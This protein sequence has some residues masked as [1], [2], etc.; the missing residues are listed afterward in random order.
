[1]K[2]SRTPIPFLVHLSVILSSLLVFASCGGSGSGGGGG[3]EEQPGIVSVPS[4]Y[5]QGCGASAYGGRGGTVY[6]VTNLED[7]GASED[8]IIGSLRAA[9]MKRDSRTIVFR[10]SGTIHLKRVLKPSNG[11]FT[12]AG[13]TAPGD[14]ITLADYP[15]VLSGLQNVVVQFLRFRLGDGITSDAYDAFEGQNNNNVMIDHCSMSWS[16]D[17]CASFYG[18]T[19]FTMQW[20]VI[21]ES[22]KGSSHPKGNHGYGGIWGGTNATFHHNL[23]ADHDSR[24]PRFDHDYVNSSCRGPVDFVNNVVF[25]WGGNSSYGGESAGAYRTVNVE[26]NYYRPGPNTKSGRRSQILN[27]TCSCGYCAERGTV[28]PGKFYVNGNVMDGASDV[29]ADNSIGVKPD[30]DSKKASILQSAHFPM[31]VELYHRESA[32]DALSSVLAYAGASKARDAVDTRVINQVMGN[33]EGKIIDSQN[34]VGGWPELNTTTPPLDS[35]SDGIP[36]EWEDAYGLN[37]N[38][39]TDGA[40]RTLDVAHLRSNL[41]IYCYDIVKDLYR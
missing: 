13:Q 26:N 40:K 39:R 6:Y 1:M 12:I 3:E 11:N 10:V 28:F 2:H 34:D 20:C 16:V 33:E 21:A 14:G 19:N 31:A 32:A 25:N 24:N 38:D 17:E 22:L 27:P 41:E 23:L 30:D 37:K 7:Y 15:L 9:L 18:N 36:D 4:N 29:T 5:F 8:E 35:D